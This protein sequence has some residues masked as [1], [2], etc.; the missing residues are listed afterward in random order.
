MVLCHANNFG[1]LDDH[2]SSGIDRHSN[3]AR[4]TIL[5]R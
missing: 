2:L 3:P 1:G 5:S 4:G